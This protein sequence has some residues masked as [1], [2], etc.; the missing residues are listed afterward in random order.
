[1]AGRIPQHFIDDLL[2][3]IDIVDVID[4]VVPLRKA[5]KNHQALCP[6]HEEK[7][8]SFTVSQDKQFY[9]CFGCGAN[10]TA[11]SFLMEYSH[12]DFVEAV[13]TLAAKAGLE[14]PRE[15]GYV[16]KDDDR[17]EL[18]E[19]LELVIEYYRR[20]LREH[21]LATRAVEYLKGRGITGELAA[22]FELGFAPPGWDNLIN[23]LGKSDAAV[24]RLAAAGMLI[25]RDTGG[26]YD[27][28]RDRVMFPIRDQRGRALGFGGRV[29]DEGTPKYLNSPETPVFHKGR[30]LYG[31]YQAR[32]ASLD[33]LY[34]VE[35]YMDALALVQFGITHV[36]ATLGT[37]V[38]R[39]HLE[40][41]FRLTSR[42]VFCF[43]GDE[44]GRQAAWRAL[45][46]SLPLLNDGRSVYFRFMPEGDDPDSFVRR[47]GRVEFEADAGLVPLSDYLLNTLRGKFELGTREGRALFLDAVAPYLRSLPASALKRLLLRDVATLAAA[48]PAD[49]DALLAS[50]GPAKSAPR[51][52][53]PARTPAR[54]TD[55]TL[56]G[57]LI[58]LLLHRPELALL[59][60]EP[61]ELQGV[62]LPGTD[63]VQQLLELIRSNPGIRCATI[64]EHWRGSR[65][66][67]RLRELA[68]GSEALDAE[69]FDLE[70]EFQ[71][72]WREVQTRKG[73]QRRKELTQ[74]E[75]LSDLSEEGKAALRSLGRPPKV[76]AGE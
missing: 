12:M 29:L 47:Q 26:Y 28:F 57:Q 9:H 24:Q 63:F 21:P 42:V 74:V 66:E 11:I 55:R 37:A 52:A 68:A 13:E 22:K 73:R 69:D 61:V 46:T 5:G 27:R 8:P 19:L 1:M 33:R 41:I 17:T 38:T 70:A 25:K 15:G 43:D 18:Y 65:Y 76:D 34:V 53:A 62:S 7:T 75:R 14:V 64:V 6:F 35:G 44:A 40:R 32:A 54:G 16:R 2:S 72:I 20:Q 4:S 56:V 10:G 48:D 23:A 58:R 71:S 67:G 59:A 45:E 31:A 50:G 39:D 3:R 36:V 60:P 51:P 30:E 49:L